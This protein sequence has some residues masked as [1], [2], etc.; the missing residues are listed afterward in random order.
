MNVFLNKL[1]NITQK[2]TQLYPSKGR[3]FC[4]FDVILCNSHPISHVSLI[5][6][7]FTQNKTL[8]N[9]QDFIHNL[10]NYCMM[11]HTNHTDENKT[12]G[13]KNTHNISFS[14]LGWYDN[15][16]WI[17]QFLQTFQYL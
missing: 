13:S 9:K 2:F 12:K 6:Y 3:T 15:F 1:E 17:W 5:F 14:E 8:Y 7:R 16:E 10:S 4:K 11:H